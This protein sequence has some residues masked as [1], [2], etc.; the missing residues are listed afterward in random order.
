MARV[1]ITG[2]A[3]FIGSNLADRLLREGHRVTI[4]DSLLRPGCSANLDW[5]A[6]RYGEGSFRLLVGSV[7]DFSLLLE[8]SAGVERVYHLAGQVAVTRS[9]VDPRGDFEDNALGTLNALE[10]A[11]QAGAN[12]VF[13]YASTNKVYGNLERL[14]I[15]AEPTRYTLRSLPKGIAETQPLDFHS[16]YGCSKGTGD[17]YTRDWA[18]TFGLRTVVLRQSCIYGPRQFG[19][20]DQGWLA[21]FAAAA[22]KNREITIYG[23]GRQV[24]DILFVDDLLDAY[25]AVVDRIDALAGEVFN[26][27]GG[28]ANSIS[29]WTEFSHLLAEHLGREVSV[30]HAA[31]RSGDQKVYVSDISKA[32]RMLGWSPRIGVREGFACLFLWVKENLQLFD[33][34]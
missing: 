2:G 17:L 1:L 11:R 34:V 30:R 31:A 10:A 25:A 20:E 21:W 16:P 7:T 32:Q 18:R 24:R 6:A 19:L 29:V 14:G 15:E 26:V 4:F 23:D 28:P 22:L 12:P 9:V 33:H 8:A 13:L 5:L 27:G 3:G